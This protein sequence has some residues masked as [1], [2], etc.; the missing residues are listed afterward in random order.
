M[1]ASVFK[2]TFKSGF[3][4]TVQVIKS[5]CIGTPNLQV[6]LGKKSFS[7]KKSPFMNENKPKKINK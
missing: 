3:G 1:N 4:G 2:T 7:S 5:S 6:R